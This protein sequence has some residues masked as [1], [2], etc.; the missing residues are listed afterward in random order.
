MAE[1]A[2]LRSSPIGQGTVSSCRP[3]SS[4]TSFVSA[5]FR[6]RYVGVCLAE[7]AVFCPFTIAQGAKSASVWC[8]FSSVFA[9]IGH[10]VHSFSKILPKNLDRNNSS[11][12]RL[13]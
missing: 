4:N 7:S 5:N 10:I 6:L 13:G 1:P 3:A 9:Q 8:M 11:E 2:A 12:I